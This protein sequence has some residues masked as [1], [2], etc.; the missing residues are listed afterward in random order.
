[1]DRSI[2]KKQETA[3]YKN[4]SR[5]NVFHWPGVYQFLILACIA[6]DGITLFS[7]IDTFLKQSVTMSRVITIAVAGVLNIAAVLLS[8]CLHNDDFTPTIKK[9]LASVI[10]GVFL[11]FFSATFVLRVAS[12]DEMYRSNSNSLGI[13]IQDSIGG[14]FAYTAE[15][16]EFEPTIG[17]IILAVILGLEPLGTSILC[18]Y[19]GY[20][21]S[22]KRKRS[23]LLTK[24][25]IDIEEAIDHDKVVLEEL[26]ADMEFDLYAYDK[27]QLDDIIAIITQRGEIAK[28]IALRKLSEHDGT[29]EGVSYLMEGDYQYENKREDEFNNS[30]H[31]SAEVNG[32]ADNRIK[33]I[34]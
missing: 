20:E 19:I 2:L 28:V 5:P 25:R 24:Q 18:F 32:K 34:A 27:E 31:F 23:Y 29:P 8:S 16:E 7:L 14:E 21:Q 30:G 4:D 17:Q 22:P 15:Q 12:M 1:M 33:S 11:M 26:N 13:A 10:L 9:M 3:L 6:A